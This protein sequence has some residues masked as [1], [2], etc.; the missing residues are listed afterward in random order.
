MSNILHILSHLVFMATI[1][2][3]CYYFLLSNEKHVLNPLHY[4]PKL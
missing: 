1:Q 2:G 4:L 3:G